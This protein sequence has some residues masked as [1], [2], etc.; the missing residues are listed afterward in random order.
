MQHTSINDLEAST[1]ALDLSEGG[2][3]N[4]AVSHFLKSN[5]EECKDLLIEKIEEMK[6]FKGDIEKNDKKNKL[7]EKEVQNENILDKDQ[8][9]SM[10][11]EYAEIR[12]KISQL[13]IELGVEESKKSSNNEKGIILKFIVVKFSVE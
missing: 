6:R 9:K 1:A 3:S 13:V 4:E 10:R 2:Y 5:F 8:L 7:R 12:E 11:T